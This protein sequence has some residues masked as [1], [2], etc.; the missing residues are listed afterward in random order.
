MRVMDQEQKACRRAP[1]GRLG[2]FDYFVLA[3][4]AVNALVIG[5]LVGLRLFAG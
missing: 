5:C 3:G 2:G 1:R 4:A